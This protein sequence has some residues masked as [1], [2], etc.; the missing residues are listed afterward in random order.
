MASKKEHDEEFVR[1]LL[2]LGAKPPKPPQIGIPDT[3]MEDIYRDVQ[4]YMASMNYAHAVQNYWMQY[5]AKMR[6]VP[7]DLR[8]VEMTESLDKQAD[9]WIERFYRWQDKHVK[10]I[11]NDY[12]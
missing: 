3:T 10:D 1:A 8:L 4:L 12:H 6:P 7:D 9:D 11:S 2:V 5:V